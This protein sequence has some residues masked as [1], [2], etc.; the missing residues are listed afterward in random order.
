MSDR[1]WTR[2]IALTAAAGGFALALAA[3]PLAPGGEFPGFALNAALAK[4]GGDNGAD[5]GG[6]KGG[7]GGKKTS[8]LVD[9]A[10]D[11]H[12]KGHTGRGNGHSKDAVSGVLGS[13]NGSHPDNH[14]ALASL[15]GSLNAAHAIANGNTNTNP[16]SRVGQIRAYM[17]ELDSGTFETA[18]DALIAASNKDLTSMD[19]DDIKSVVSGVND[20]IEDNNDSN[21]TSDELAVANEINDPDRDD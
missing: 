2:R 13:H 7:K 18:A 21:I 3:A 8:T 1:T 6:G 16:N 11:S 5:K 15:L 19:I 14:G 10:A 17:I 9:P 12:G 20:L 4:G